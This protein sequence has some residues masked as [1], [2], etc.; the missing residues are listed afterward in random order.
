MPPSSPN[1]SL[2]V[3]PSRDSDQKLESSTETSGSF[4]QNPDNM[5]VTGG[6]FNS[7]LGHHVT[8]NVTRK[9]VASNPRRVFRF[10]DTEP[11]GSSGEGASRVRDRPC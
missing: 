9:Q 6:Q 3:T 7:T 2:Q 1:T 8:I 4:F 11:E 5:R 10:L